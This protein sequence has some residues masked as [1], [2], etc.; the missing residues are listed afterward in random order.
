MDTSGE[1]P[2]LEIFKVFP[3]LCLF[4]KKLI[5]QKLEFDVSMVLSSPAI[6]NFSIFQNLCGNQTECSGFHCCPKGPK[7]SSLYNLE[8]F[9]MQN[10]HVWEKIVLIPE[11]ERSTRPGVE[12]GISITKLYFPV[13]TQNHLFAY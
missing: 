13:K 10:L 7:S 11:K 9:C 3:N 8:Y 5:L 2:Y 4:P 12:S 6:Q 1:G